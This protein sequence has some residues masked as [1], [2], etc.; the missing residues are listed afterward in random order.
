MISPFFTPWSELT[1][2]WPGFEQLFESVRPQ[3]KGFPKFNVWKENDELVVTAELPSLE[4]EALKVNAHENRLSV[5]GDLPARSKVGGET[6]HRNE[7]AYGKFNR[8]LRLPFRADAEKT[9]A[10]LENGVLRVVVH[11]LAEDKPK[12]IAVSAH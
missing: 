11:A 1:R 4:P 8:E 9:T 12:Q 3:S 5:S 7:R 6:Y 10:T 2:S